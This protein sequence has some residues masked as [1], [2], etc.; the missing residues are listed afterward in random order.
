DSTEMSILLVAAFGGKPNIENLD[1]C[2]TRLRVTVKDISLVNK[3]EL[4][5]LGAAGVVVSGNGVQAI[6]GTKSDNLK[7]DMENYMS[8]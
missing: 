4:K 6:F 8:K 2:I 3:D 1:A 7:T 5:K